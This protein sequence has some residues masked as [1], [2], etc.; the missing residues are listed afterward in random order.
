MY[1]RGSTS[2]RKKGSLPRA[3]EADRGDWVN[4]IGNLWF[5]SVNPPWSASHISDGVGFFFF[6]SSQILLRSRQFCAG[7]TE[8][9]LM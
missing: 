4:L 5:L 2:C 1:I 9:A 3:R 8:C 6:F 7:M